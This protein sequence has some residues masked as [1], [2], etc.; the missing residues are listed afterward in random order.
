MEVGTYTHRGIKY[1]T[2]T[3]WIAILLLATFAFAMH[4]LT[5]PVSMK[6][7]PV[8][9]KEGEPLL[10][11][12]TLTNPGITETPYEYELYVNGEKVFEG[13][14]TIAALSSEHYRYAYENPLKLGEQTN[15]LLKV[16]TPDNE[17]TKVISLPAYAPQ[18][19]TSFVSFATFSTSIATFSSSMGMSSSMA[20]MSTMAG[21][22]NN[23]GVG[24]AFNVG[25]IFSVILIVMLIQLDMTEHMAMRSALFDRLRRRFSKLAT[26]L[27]I[28]FTGMV[29]TRIA[30]VLG[31]MV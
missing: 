8:V 1:K 11:S 30:L 26:I 15:F 28:I 21:Y 24:T 22:S 23:F 27:L 3:I 29:L 4:G 17:Y 6:V 16:K 31:G 5:D 9:P 25:L 13:D 20:G 12:F 10:V 2:F 7:M 18:V 14:T 19:W